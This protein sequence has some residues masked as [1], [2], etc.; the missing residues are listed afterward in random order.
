MRPAAALIIVTV[1]AACAVGP[2]FER[3]EPPAAD[4]FTADPLPA[5][6]ASA[7]VQKGAAQRFLAGRDLPGE[8]WQ[9][10]RSPALDALTKDAIK[11]SPN[12]KSAEA[13]LRQARE[14]RFAGEG[15]FFPLVQGSFNASRNKTAAS[16]SPATATGSLYY[17]QYTAQL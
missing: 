14:M 4:R 7:P 17:N 9:L 5:T 6:T 10:F 15:A 3:P 2:D 12:I 13:A 16:V 8:W 1:L 11:A